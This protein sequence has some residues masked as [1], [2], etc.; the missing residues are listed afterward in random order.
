M[1]DN[2]HSSNSSQEKKGPVAWMAHNSIA[3]NL[4]MLIL[5]GGG[6]WTA[7]HIQKEVFPD[8]ELDI[9]EVEVEYPGA[10]PSEVEQGIL[11]PIE[12]AVRG[13]QGIKEI[14]ST[15]REGR[16]TIDI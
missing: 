16:A 8:Y 3:S 6:I 15:A 7:L 11:L 2:Q 5:I 14:T 10:A 13:I 4:L 1:S 12:E 9:V